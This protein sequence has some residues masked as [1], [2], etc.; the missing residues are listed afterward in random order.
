[1]EKEIIE[2]IEKEVKSS[3]GN[4]GSLFQ[5]SDSVTEK[6]NLQRIEATLFLSARFLD[7]D[8]IVKFT[9]I[10]PITVKVLMEKL[11][12][13]YG[14]GESAIVVHKR[15]V[16]GQSFY[17]M[18]VKQQYHNLINK[19]VTGQAEFSKAEQ[20]TLAIIA[21]KQPIKQSSIV[22]IRGNKA[23]NHIKHMMEVGLVKGKKCSRTVELSLSEDFYN[24]FSLDKEKKGNVEVKKE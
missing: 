8:E 20:E 23:Y 13:K 1:M 7:T 21:Y 24:Y 16:E 2:R 18:D 11:I 3:G 4:T 10:N 22:R 14:T 5:D 19:I 15:D 12:K 9:S 17:K 6:E